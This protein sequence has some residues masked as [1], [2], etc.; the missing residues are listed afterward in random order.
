MSYPKEQERIIAAM[1]PTWCFTH[2]EALP[3]ETCETIKREH[4]F[5]SRCFDCKRE[6]AAEGE[7][8]TEP[9]NCYQ[10]CRIRLKSFYSYP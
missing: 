10:G 5:I 7:V 2:G 4:P 6:Y 1:G 3:C 8:N 9:C